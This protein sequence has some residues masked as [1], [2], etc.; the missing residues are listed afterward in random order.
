MQNKFKMTVEQNIFLAKR[1]IID[2]IYKSARLEGLNVTFPNTETIINGGTVSGLKAD[3]IVS[4]NNLKHAWYFVFDNI[5]HPTNYAFI[6]ELNKVV[7][8]NLIYG[9]GQIRNFPVSVGEYIPPLPIEVDIKDEINAAHGIDNSTERSVTLMLNLMRRQIFPD[10]NKRT[11]ML[12]A[13]HE[14]IRNGAGV[15]SV[16]LTQIQTFSEHLFD[17]YMTGNMDKAKSFVFDCC[18]DGISEP[19]IHTDVDASSHVTKIVT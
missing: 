11:A 1:N 14:M 15:I 10:G 19:E 12:A 17:F 2:N 16:P 6:C 8:A 3:E 7:G 5:D 4:V 13:N 9:A 18:I